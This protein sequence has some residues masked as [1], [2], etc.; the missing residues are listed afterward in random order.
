MVISTTFKPERVFPVSDKWTPEEV[1]EFFTLLQE[2]K[3]PKKFHM[4]CHDYK[5]QSNSGVLEL[6][7]AFINDYTLVRAKSLPQFVRD[8]FFL[9]VDNNDCLNRFSNLSVA[10]VVFIWERLIEALFQHEISQRRYQ[11]YTEIFFR[12]SF[13]EEIDRRLVED[14]RKDFYG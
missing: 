4:Q 7:K 2:K 3:L 8:G 11:M 1:N 14:I 10:E 12:P 6:R 5:L 13:N 9:P